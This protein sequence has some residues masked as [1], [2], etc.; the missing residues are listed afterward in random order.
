[1]SE[2][3]YHVGKLIPIKKK[4][5]EDLIDQ[6]SKILKQNSLTFEDMGFDKHI[7]A[8]NIRS[9]NEYFK[10]LCGE[11]SDFF[12]MRYFIIED[13]LY[14]IHNNKLNI[15]DEIFNIDW[16]YD[17]SINYEL[18]YYNGGCSFNEAIDNAIKR[19]IKKWN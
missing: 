14:E 12:Y 5:N 10:I 16:N 19:K 1:M 9:N 2:D 17:G 7:E 15:Y 4:E 6:I 8:N 11:F 3:V 13:I 18:K